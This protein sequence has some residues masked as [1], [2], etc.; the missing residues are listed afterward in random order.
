MSEREE[1]DPECMKAGELCAAC[2]AAIA[3]L[4]P[5]RCAKCRST[6]VAI[7]GSPFNARLRCLDCDPATGN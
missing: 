6:H 2:K 5:I 1:H 3:A 7:E 4:P